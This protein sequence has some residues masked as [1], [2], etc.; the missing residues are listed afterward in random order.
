[1]EIQKFLSGDRRDL[2]GWQSNF[3]TA[4]KPVRLCSYWAV[5]NARTR[6]DPPVLAEVPGLSDELAPT[7][8]VPGSPSVGEY[9][10]A[11]P[12]RLPIPLPVVG[13]PFH[14]MKALRRIPP[15]YP[16]PAIPFTTASGI[17]APGADFDF[18]LYPICQYG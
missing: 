12:S 8:S 2:L 14:Q 17:P 7:D 16:S 18:C 5:R 3:P 11:V 13:S 4:P 9:G 10:K 15:R 1:M 6:S